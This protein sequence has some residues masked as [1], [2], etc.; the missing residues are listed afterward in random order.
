MSMLFLGA[1]P[2]T[3]TQREL[4]ILMGSLTNPDQLLEEY[5]R[6][7]RGYRDQQS[8]QYANSLWI[9][10][11]F[12]LYQTYKD[13]LEN[14][15]G[16]RARRVD[17]TNSSTLSQ[18]N[19]WIS[20]KTKDRIPSIVKRLNHDTK[21]YLVNALHFSD[22]WYVPF[23]VTED[24]IFHAVNELSSSRKKKVPTMAA[25]SDSSFKYARMAT[26]SRRVEVIGIPY[27]NG[28]FEMRIILPDASGRNAL[29]ILE[30]EMV[31]DSSAWKW[32]KDQTSFNPFFLPYKK[33]NGDGLNITVTMPKFKTSS[34]VD[35]V[36]IL[37]KMSVQQIF[38][39]AELGKLT[40]SSL[41]V[42]DISHQAEI[43]VNEEGTEASAATTVELVLLSAT[44]EI[45]KVNI[46]RPFIYIVQDTARN[47]PVLVGRV[48][49]PTQISN[50]N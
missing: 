28:D 19:N 38:S 26:K 8:F 50:T 9:A 13:N 20:K 37:K 49:D 6:L 36:D 21:L 31:T 42:S 46:N 39:V 16:A 10:K 24:K 17:F 11:G 15:L 18:I 48:M 35:A 41:E 30:H 1:T 5:N 32:T 7:T 25:E 45:V 22:K 23:T 4:G 43:S 47:V 3:E 14:N 2:D 12:Q 44:T 33:L 27:K 29:A 34:S 40:N